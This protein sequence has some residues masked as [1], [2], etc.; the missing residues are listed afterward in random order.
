VFIALRTRLNDDEDGFTLIELLVVVIIIGILAAIAVPT[1]LSQREKAANSAQQADLRNAAVAEE[2]Y[3]TDN[4]AGG[5]GA[6]PT[7]AQLTANAGFKRSTAV[8]MWATGGSTYCLATSHGTSKTWYSLAN[9][10]G[11]P[12]PHVAADPA[13]AAGAAQAHCAGGVAVA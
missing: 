9:T 1:F 13:A 10:D 12:V 7:A 8:S 6:Y 2:S 4:G 11:A 5:S 3:F